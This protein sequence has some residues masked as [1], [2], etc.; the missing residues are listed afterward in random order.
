MTFL[1]CLFPPD[2]SKMNS[3][4]FVAGF[5]WEVINYTANWYLLWSN[6]W[7][8]KIA[9]EEE[10]NNY[11]YDTGI[12]ET[13]VISSNFILKLVDVFMDFFST[14][15]FNVPLQFLLPTLHKLPLEVVAFLLEIL[16]NFEKLYKLFGDVFHYT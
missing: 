5:V 6:E 4:Q 8:K 3:G 15:I 14:T 9:Y 2:I 11:D 12:D 16:E 10:E 7:S 13:N 1:Y